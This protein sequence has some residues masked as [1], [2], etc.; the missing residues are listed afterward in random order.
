MARVPLFRPDGEPILGMEKFLR[1]DATLMNLFASGQADWVLSPNEEPASSPR[2]SAAAHHG[3][4][5][6][7]ELAVAATLARILDRTGAATRFS[8]AAS[9]QRRGSVRRQ[10]EQAT[11]ARG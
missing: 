6:D 8:F 2:A 1:Q 10:L 3:D 9:G 11:A 5:D 7:D 4:F